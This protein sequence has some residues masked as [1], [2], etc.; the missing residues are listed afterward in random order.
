MSGAIRTSLG[1]L[2]DT[3]PSAIARAVLRICAAADFARADKRL[4]VLTITDNGLVDAWRRS[5]VAI[6]IAER[7]APHTVVGIYTRRVQQIDLI[8][9]IQARA[10]E[11]QPAPPKSPP[12]GR[13][14]NAAKGQPDSPP[15]MVIATTPAG[16]VRRNRVA[17]GSTC[18]RVSSA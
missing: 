4:V 9:D 10:A 12:R 6:T 14:R 2:A 8:D 5:A 1:A 18:P 16:T 15:A 11:L 13:P 7:T 17:G 3:T